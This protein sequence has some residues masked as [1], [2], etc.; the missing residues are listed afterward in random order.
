MTDTITRDQEQIFKSFLLTSICAA[1]A[2]CDLD[3]NELLS[4][5]AAMRNDWIS[6]DIALEWLHSIGLFD[7]VVEESAP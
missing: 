6:C 5:G 2:R 1:V 7:Q 4:I 3:R